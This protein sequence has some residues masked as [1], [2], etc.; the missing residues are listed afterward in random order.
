MKWKDDVRVEQAVR[1]RVMQKHSLLSLVIFAAKRIG[2]L[3]MSLLLFYEHR[4]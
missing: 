1:P 2:D 4:F 3:R